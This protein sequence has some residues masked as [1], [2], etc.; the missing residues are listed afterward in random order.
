MSA[1][2]DVHILA[3][4]Y[5]V[6]PVAK[7]YSDPEGKETDVT[8]FEENRLLARQEMVNSVK[9]GQPQPVSERTLRG[10]GVTACNKHSKQ[11]AYLARCN[12]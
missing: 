9:D 6:K 4:K 10:S 7:K 3:M 12:G 1:L 5:G 8:L 11:P 2:N